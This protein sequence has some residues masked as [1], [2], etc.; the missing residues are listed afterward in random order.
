MTWGAVAVAGAAVVGGYIG[1]QGAKS[2]ADTQANA[3]YAGQQISQNEFNTITAQE[4]P[5]MQ[6]GY[7]ALN[8]LDYLLGIGDPSQYGTYTT[9]QLPGSQYAGGKF[10][11]N[12]G[13]FQNGQIPSRYQ[14]T[15][16][17]T[18]FTP[19]STSAG[20]FG[21]LLKPFDIS[22]W[23]K[24]SPAYNFQRQQGMQGVLNGDEASMG[25]LSGAAQ[26]DLMSFNQNL[27]N[28][29][30]NNAF[31]M[32]Q[33]Q[34][35]NIYSRLA[36]MTQLGQ[37]AAS[38]TGQQ[39]TALAGQAAQSATNVGSAQAAGQVGS[40]NAWAGAISNLGYL[41]YLTQGNGS[42]N[43]G[44][45]GSSMGSAF[46]DRRLK[47]DITPVGKTDS[48]LTVYTYRFSG[49]DTFHMGIMADEA[50]EKFPDAVFEG[51]DG[52]FRVNYGKIN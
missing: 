9:Q 45:S 18:T 43:A 8:Q 14:N 20:G 51:E 12:T 4:A 40:A 36:G 32:Y 26:K 48:G 21:S 5:F 41:P 24:L 46:S 29:S 35:G 23:K 11:G 6:G 42:S 28:T 2:A 27:A 13:D 49:S 44:A 22:D 19:Y 47:T 7:G 39:G 15:Q 38:N 25:S 16:G 10:F 33:A 31:N 17:K 1:S 3:A 50:K 30:F 52:Y 37:A 34:Q